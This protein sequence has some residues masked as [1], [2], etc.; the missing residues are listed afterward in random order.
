MD[1]ETRDMVE[2]R[3]EACKNH[4]EKQQIFYLEKM[5]IEA[6]YPYFFNFWEDLRPVFGGG[7]DGD[8]ESIDWDSYHFLIEVGQLAGY[9]LAQISVCFNQ[10]GDGTLLELL[11]MRCAADKENPTAEDGELHADM[12]A[13]KCMEIIERFFEAM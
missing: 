9:D 10:K 8:P 13:E 7:E 5:L 4:P 2:C 11:D 12:T 1:N 3:M 6:G